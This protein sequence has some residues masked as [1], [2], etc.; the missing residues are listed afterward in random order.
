M[1]L[2]LAGGIERSI[3]CS[4][5]AQC[6]WEN[7]SEVIGHN[8]VPLSMK[9]ALLYHSLCLGSVVS[10]SLILKG[11][12][13]WDGNFPH[14]S[15]WFTFLCPQWLFFLTAFWDGVQDCNSFHWL[16]FLSKNE[17]VFFIFCFSSLFIPVS[18]KPFSFLKWTSLLVTSCNLE[19]LNLR[20]L[21]QSVFFF[22][23]R[24]CYNLDSSFLMQ[25]FSVSMWIPLIYPSYS[26]F[27]SLVDEIRVA[28]NKRWKGKP[29]CG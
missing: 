8:S 7:R 22:F 23:T 10:M 26:T 1:L 16:F 3:G 9:P 6:W 25:V 13:L 4:A 21:K 29:W 17:I 12:L 24:K 14:S 27:V 28:W 19:I 15:L 2:S 20:N 5:K 18:R 11:L